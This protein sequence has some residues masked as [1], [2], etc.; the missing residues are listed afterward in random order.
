M[1]SRNKFSTDE[2]FSMEPHLMH[3]KV[4]STKRLQFLTWTLTLGTNTFSNSNINM[5]AIICQMVNPSQ[6]HQSEYK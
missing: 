2:T 1:L 3:T 4:S 5:L 6:P